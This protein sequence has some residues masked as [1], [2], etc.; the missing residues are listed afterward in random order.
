[1]LALAFIPIVMGIIAG[2]LVVILD[3]NQHG[4]SLQI[5]L[6]V[7]IVISIIMMYLAYRKG[8]LAL[9]NL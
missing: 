4:G 5:L 6:I 8:R 7:L 9:R 2:S 3:L 1:M